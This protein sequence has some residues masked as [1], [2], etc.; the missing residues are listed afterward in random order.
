V[1]ASG[2][3]AGFNGGL[4]KPLLIVQADITPKQINGEPL[5]NF[6]LYGWTNGHTSNLA[7]DAE[8]RHSGWGLSVDHKFGRDWN[9]FGRWGQRT[10]GEGSFDRALTLGFE[11]GGRAWGRGNDAIGLA[12]GWLHTDSAWQN[13][14]AAD[15]SLVGYTAQ[16]SERVAELYYRMKLNERIELSPDVQLIQRPGGQS[17]AKR[18]TL[19][20]LRAGIGF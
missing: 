20:G 17:G 15:P 3:G 6:R 7:G 2:A 4:G 5:G 16:G 1:F 14:T 12:V 11:H 19:W 8:Q 18:V 13:A 10:S 9:V